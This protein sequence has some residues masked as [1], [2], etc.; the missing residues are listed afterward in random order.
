MPNIPPSP[1]PSPSLSDI[2]ASIIPDLDLLEFYEAQ[3]GSG[4]SCVTKCDKNHTDPMNCLN[5]GVC[6]VYSVIG[7]LC[8]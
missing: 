2:C 6:N 1:S 4:W 5:A 7:P 8:Q 3:N